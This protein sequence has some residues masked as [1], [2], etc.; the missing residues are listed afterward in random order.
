MEWREKQQPRG[1]ILAD[2]MGLGKTLTCISHILACMQRKDEEYNSKSDDTDTD[3]NDE[4][5]DNL[6]G[7]VARGR[8]DCKCEYFIYICKLY[9]HIMNTL[10]YIN[11]MQKLCSF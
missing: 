8:K 2:D 4:N 9:I 3:E 10:L 5:N 1:G 6:K 7:W 11:H